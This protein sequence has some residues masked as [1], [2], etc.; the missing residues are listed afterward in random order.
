MPKGWRRGGNPAYDILA[1]YDSAAETAQLSLSNHV[2]EWPVRMV[3]APVLHVFW[4]DRPPIDSMQRKAL[5]RAFDE[6]SLYDETT[7]TVRDGAR[8][9]PRAHF[10]AARAVTH[11]P[12][13]RR[14]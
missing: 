11:R 13:H 4:L 14:A 2:R 6:A 12:S 3:A 7:R 8:R 1:R 10:V 5:A 9:Q